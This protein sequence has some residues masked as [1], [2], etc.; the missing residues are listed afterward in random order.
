MKLKSLA[1]VLLFCEV[2]LAQT[3]PIKHEWVLVGWQPIQW[4][5][6]RPKHTCESKLALRKYLFSIPYGEF[7]DVG[8]L[9]IKQK[10]GKVVISNGDGQVV[11]V[12]HWTRQGETMVVESQVVYRTVRIVGQTIPEP[13][14]RQVFTSKMRGQW[15]V[16]GDGK[17]YKPMPA[18]DLDNLSQWAGTRETTG[19]PR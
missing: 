4:E 19:V 2:V 3:P 8:C 18:M 13:S 9:L 10:D 6:P 14:K 15:E 16:E 11:A 1:F 17:R 12:G 5:S 7:A